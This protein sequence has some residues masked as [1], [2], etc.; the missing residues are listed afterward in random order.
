MFDWVVVGT[1][2]QHRG[3]PLGST[4]PQDGEKRDDS[5]AAAN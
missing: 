2:S 5:G 3:P 1:E 4:D